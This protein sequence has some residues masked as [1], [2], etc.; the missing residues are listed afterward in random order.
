MAR[1]PKFSRKFLI[2]LNKANITRD[3]PNL[4]QFGL[5]G[6]NHGAPI[7]NSKLS[8]YPNENN[9]TRSF[10]RSTLDEVLKDFSDTHPGAVDLDTSDTN[11]A[12]LQN[13]IKSLVKRD[14]QLGERGIGVQAGLI[15]RDR[16]LK[17]QPSSFM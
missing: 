4:T 2:D 13:S 7:I 6:N 15:P 10:Q 11:L 12:F 1:Q 9:P 5:T 17:P 16:G 8:E 14:T 3:N